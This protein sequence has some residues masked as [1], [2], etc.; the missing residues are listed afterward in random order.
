[1]HLLPSE[2]SKMCLRSGLC[3]KPY[4][5]AYSMPPRFS[6]WW[7]PGR[8]L[9][10]TARKTQPH[11]RP[12]ASH[13]GALWASGQAVAFGPCSFGGVSCLL[14]PK[15]K[16]PAGKQHRVQQGH[17]Q[18]QQNHNDDSL[19]ADRTLTVTRH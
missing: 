16:S 14:T 1:M 13:L 5:G 6:N 11:S 8:E 3:P 7:S 12:L 4:W 18:Q 19:F 9:A 10:A 2:C 17:H 15:H